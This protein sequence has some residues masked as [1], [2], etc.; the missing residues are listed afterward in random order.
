MK[1]IKL[2]PLRPN[3]FSFRSKRFAGFIL[4]LFAVVFT[5]IL[6]ILIA[7][8]VASLTLEGRANSA[9]QALT[10]PTQVNAL[11]RQ[12]A[13]AWMQKDADAFASLFMTD[14][15]FIV[16]G[17]RWSGQTAIR[18][19]ASAFAQGAAEVTVEIHR[20]LIDGNQ[21][22]VEWH[23]QDTEKATGRRNQADDVIMIDFSGGK[24]RRWREY[25]DTQTPAV[26]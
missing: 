21:A 2:H 17:N 24:I 19:V 12:A 16:P 25:I 5:S 8:P 3:L 6:S 14:G 9:S 18:D 22:A 10:S 4:I 1:K 13:D 20:I 11:V 23:W 26:L 7:S 15:E